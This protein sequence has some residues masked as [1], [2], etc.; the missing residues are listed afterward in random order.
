MSDQQEMLADLDKVIGVLTEETDLT[1][2]LIGASF[3]DRCLLTLLK[4]SMA[5]SRISDEILDPQKGFAG[6][7]QARADLAYSFGLISE[8]D[9]SDLLLIER[10]RNHFAHAYLLES[11]DHAD[12]AAL[13]DEIK[14]G[15]GTTPRARFCVAVGMIAERLQEHLP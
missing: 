6:N 11:F 13:C 9:Y 1:A 8:S 10:I 14:A 5:K 3:L 4:A 15:Q 12:I 2:A 7:M